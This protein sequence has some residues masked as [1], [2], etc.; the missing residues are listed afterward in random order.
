M[1]ERPIVQ[2]RAMGSRRGYFNVIGCHEMPKMIKTP[3]GPLRAVRLGRWDFTIIQQRL[4]QANA[5]KAANA[6]NALNNLP[7]HEAKPR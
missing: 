1:S 4:T 7:L 3:G 5:L 6:L 2:Y